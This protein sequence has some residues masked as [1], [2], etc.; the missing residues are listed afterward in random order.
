MYNKT[1]LV[2]H[3]M[4]FV[5]PQGLENKIIFNIMT[6]LCSVFAYLGKGLKNIQHFQLSVDIRR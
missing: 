2:K 1:W 3:K 4:R 5:A 6:C